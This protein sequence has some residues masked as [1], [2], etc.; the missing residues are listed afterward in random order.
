MSPPSGHH[1]HQFGD[2]SCRAVR[3]EAGDGEAAA[4]RVVIVLEEVDTLSGTSVGWFL[5]GGHRLGEET[6]TLLFCVF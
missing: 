1:A 5:S 2:I 4:V 3:H 6:L